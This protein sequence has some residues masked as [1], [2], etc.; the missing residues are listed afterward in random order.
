[1]TVSIL[2]G[3]I[4]VLSHLTCHSASVTV[5]AWASAGVT[6]IT[7]TV[8]VG[9]IH[10]ILITV[11]AMA[12]TMILTGVMDAATLTTAM[13]DIL[14]TTAVVTRLITVTDRAIMCH[15]GEVTAP[16]QG[17]H[18]QLRVMA[19]ANQPYPLRALTQGEPAQHH[20]LHHLQHQPHNPE[21]VQ[22]QGGRQ[23]HL[24]KAHIPDLH[25]S[26]TAD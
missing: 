20:L 3:I 25:Q 13:V 6:L 5:S 2:T 21:Q 18:I 15:A 14:P 12:V 19:G 7:D 22:Q 4:T 16:P 24:K 10:I 26:R 11:M 8:T 9:I 17:D 23:M 1:M